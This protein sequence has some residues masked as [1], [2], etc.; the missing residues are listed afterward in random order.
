MNYFRAPLL[1]CACLL[2]SAFTFAQAP[3]DL[4]KTASDQYKS[5]QFEQAATSYEKILAQGYPSPEVYFNLGNCYYKL[6]QIAKATLNFERAAKLSPEDED[7]RH[8]LKLSELKTID[9]IQPVPQLAVITWWK[10]FTASYSSGGWAIYAVIFVWLALLAV[11][12]SLFI[13]MKKITAT[14][15]VLFFILSVSFLMLSFQQKTREQ[16]ASAAIL[17]V[18]NSFIKSAPDFNGSNLFMIHEG[19]KF[20]ILDQVGTWY[21]IRLADGKVGWLE[22]GSFERI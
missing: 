15:G 12:F 8:N 6:N 11:A 10:E 18:S 9:K 2:L 7:I 20:N 16:N 21:K 19:V 14:V 22:K 1:A 3:R 4:Y 17:M 13:G 5:S